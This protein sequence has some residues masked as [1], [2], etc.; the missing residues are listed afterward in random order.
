[1]VKLVVE[2]FEVLNLYSTGLGVIIVDLCTDENDVYALAV[3]RRG[4]ERYV[5][6]PIAPLP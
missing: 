1:M 3:H 6:V 5:N 2:W 4:L